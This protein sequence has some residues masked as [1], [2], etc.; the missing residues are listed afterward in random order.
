M[1]R[2]E[3]GKNAGH[4]APIQIN[5]NGADAEELVKLTGCNKRYAQVLVR[6]RPY[7]RAED[8]LRVAELCSGVAATR[9]LRLLFSWGYTDE[10]AARP[11]VGRLLQTT[12]LKGGTRIEVRTLEKDEVRVSLTHPLG[13]ELISGDLC[14]GR[15]EGIEPASIRMLGAWPHELLRW[16]SSLRL[17]AVDLLRSEATGEAASLWRGDMP[18]INETPFRTGVQR[19][20]RDLAVVRHVCEEIATLPDESEDSEWDWTTDGCGSGGVSVPNG[21]WVEC[22]NQHD[23]C[24]SLKGDTFSGRWDCDIA[25][26]DCLASKGAGV[27]APVYGALAIVYWCGVRIGG[28]VSSHRGEP[29]EAEWPDSR[30][31]PLFHEGANRGCSYWLRLLSIEQIRDDTGLRDFHFEFGHGPGEAVNSHTKATVPFRGEQSFG[32]L[33][34]T[35]MSG[36]TPHCGDRFHKQLYIRCS[37]T[38]IGKLFFFDFVCDGSE[39]AYTL[40]L[41]ITHGS[42][43]RFRLTL[44]F[45]SSCLYVP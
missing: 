40:I 10:E 39:E 7:R 21:D 37:T 4:G 9:V 34:E 45:D 25:F 35:V 24:Y 6:H 12:T 11:P 15:H 28:T 18:E 42:G 41:P 8:L 36:A 1:E 3:R 31:P 26:S 38:E 13:F 22:C 32:A 14:D 17:S 30:K 19:L 44:R 20:S 27:S 33:G 43:G 29:R 5:L 2:K 16:K 23:I